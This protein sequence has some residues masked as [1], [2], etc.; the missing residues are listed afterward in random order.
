MAIV[1]ALAGLRWGELIAL[2]LEKDIDYRRNVVRVTEQ[3]QKRLPLP[4]KTPAGVREVD[5]TPLV[6]KVMESTSRASG[7]IFSPDGAPTW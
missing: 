3:L 2:R 7:F 5:M 4:P 1:A 6:R